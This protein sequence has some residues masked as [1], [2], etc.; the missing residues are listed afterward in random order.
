MDEKHLLAAL[1]AVVMYTLIILFPAKGQISVALVDPAVFLCIQRFVD[2]IA[3]TGLFLEE[4]R[5]CVQPSW[6]SWVHVTAKRRAVLTLYLVHWSYSVYHDLPSFACSQ[7]GFMPA[8]APKFLWQ[9]ETREKWA[10]FYHQWL[11]H[12]GSEPY[13]MSEFHGI[14]P[15]T[16]L[17]PRSERW[18]EDADELGILFFS[19]GTCSGRRLPRTS[20]LTNAVNAN[21]R[22]DAIYD[23]ETGGILVL[24]A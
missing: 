20:L 24:T 8:P 5:I 21:E 16:A 2:Y 17:D 18:L 23:Y 22:D 7:L 9:A 15:G 14:Q 13:M 12:W 4:E 19:I 1:Q 3:K 10:G 6:E 11:A